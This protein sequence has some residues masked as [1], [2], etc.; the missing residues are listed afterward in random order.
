[1]SK[2]ILIVDD[3]LGTSEALHDRLLFQGYQSFC[4]GDGQE[5]ISFL[6]MQ[7]V[8]LVI[9]DLMMP[10]KDGYSVLAWIRNN[11]STKMTKVIIS[12]AKDSLQDIKQLNELGADGY[13]AKP[14]KLSDLISQ[15]KNCL[16]GSDSKAINFENAK[17]EA[18]KKQLDPTIQ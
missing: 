3:N 4:V 11:E 17:T 6:E 9:L 8:D 13:V 10:Q 14:Y 1:M 16:Y 2:T 15:I 18:L 12:S 7:D 5:A